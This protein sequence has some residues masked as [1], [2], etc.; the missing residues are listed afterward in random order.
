LVWSIGK[1][2]LF[3]P[4]NASRLINAP[5]KNLSI[6]D[7]SGLGTLNHRRHHCICISIL[8]HDFDFDTWNKVH[9]VFAPATCLGRASLASK[10]SDLGYRHTFY[11]NFHYGISDF[12]QSEGLYDGF[13]S[14][15]S[16]LSGWLAAFIPNAQL[17]PTV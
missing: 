3:C 2:V 12:M 13:D 17:M 9:A 8:Y 1:A 14:F 11:V 6:S 16:A 10:T 4:S 15:N 5:N 7:R